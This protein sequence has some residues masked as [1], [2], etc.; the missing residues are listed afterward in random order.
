MKSWLVCKGGQFQN[1]RDPLVAPPHLGRLA[2]S[3]AR[4]WAPSLEGLC[5]P[6]CSL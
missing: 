6:L 3:L 2:W 5:N 4:V 1:L